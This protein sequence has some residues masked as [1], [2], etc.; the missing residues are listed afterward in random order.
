MSHVSDLWN[1]GSM[2]PID[3]KHLGELLEV[4]GARLS[5][6]KHSIA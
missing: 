6:T 1:D 5:D 3:A 2:C 4:L